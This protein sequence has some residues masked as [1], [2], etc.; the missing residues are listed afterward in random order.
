[1][2]GIYSICIDGQKVG[3]ATVSREGLYYSFRCECRLPKREVCK[4]FVSCGADGVLLGTPF[5]EGQVFVLRTKLPIK[6][7]GEGQMEFSVVFDGDFQ[8]EKFVPVRETEPFPYLREIKKAYA[9][10]RGGIRGIVVKI[11]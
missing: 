5:P 1:M 9:Q 6:R 3:T 2:E 8:N 10:E 7:F 4:I 11:R